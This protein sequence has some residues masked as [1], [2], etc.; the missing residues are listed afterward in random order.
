MKRHGL[1]YDSPP[2][3][4]F[5]SLKAFS[6]PAVPGLVPILPWFQNLTCSS[7][8]IKYK[9]IFAGGISSSLLPSGQQV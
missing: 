6:S 4:P 3:F 5:L 2:N 7:L 1:F 9:P 8:L